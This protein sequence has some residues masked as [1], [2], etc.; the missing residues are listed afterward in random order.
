DGDLGPVTCFAGDGLDLDCA[1]FYFRHVELEQLTD[2]LGVSLRHDDLRHAAGFSELEH[3]NPYAVAYA[4]SLARQLLARRHAAF[5]ASQ[6][7]DHVVARV[8]DHL[9]ALN[10]T[11]G[12]SALACLEFLFDQLL[13]RFAQA[14]SY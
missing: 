9:D 12:A 7:Y 3:V 6:V 8:A 13:F 2:Q 1:V 4:V 11:R 10:L 5:H 14:L